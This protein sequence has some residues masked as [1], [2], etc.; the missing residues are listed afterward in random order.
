MVMDYLKNGAYTFINF[1]T[2]N[3]ATNNMPRL[4]LLCEVTY[5][6]QVT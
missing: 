5:G 3:S 6:E 1:F 4:A 2:N